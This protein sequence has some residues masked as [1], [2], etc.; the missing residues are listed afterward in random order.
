MKKIYI[1]LLIAIGAV[2]LLTSSAQAAPYLL[3]QDTPVYFQF[4]NLEQV[5]QSLGNNI[6]VP[7][8]Y[9]TAGNWGLINVSSIQS[10]A[11]SL[12]NKDIAGGPVIWSD[13]GPGGTRGQITGIFYDIDLINGTRASGGTLDLYWSDAG[14][15]TVT[16]LDMAGVTSGPD[17]ATVT[18][19]TSGTFLARLNF[20]PGIIDGDG[21]TTIQ[22]STDLTTGGLSGQADS[23]ADVDTSVVG[24]WTALLDNDYFHVDVDG[25]GTDGEPGETRD[26][27]FS[28]FYNALPSWDGGPGI[29]G[30]R[31]NDPGRVYTAVVPEPGTMI[32]F[33][34]GLL[35]LAGAAR[36]KNS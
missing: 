34:V 8:G 12:P 30:L 1:N 3:P 21:L 13:D 20:A 33:G 6:V 4:N 27:R 7:G 31:S 28:N 2:F 9:G 14:S 10:G 24:A 23:F 32:L 16:A 35:G 25:D 22:S 19:F 5:D 29:V 11:V 26:L 18:Q 17:L 36:R 15:D